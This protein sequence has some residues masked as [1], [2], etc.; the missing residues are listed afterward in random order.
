MRRRPDGEEP[1]ATIYVPAWLEARER[2]AS[3][4]DEDARALLTSAMEQ[5]ESAWE[6]VRGLQRWAEQHAERLRVDD[7]YGALLTFATSEVQ[8]VFRGL[9][10][11]LAALVEAWPGRDLPADNDVSARL[12][13]FAR[14]A[15]VLVLATGAAVDVPDEFR[16]LVRQVA[17]LRPGGPWA[18]GLAATFAAIQDVSD[19]EITADSARQAVDFLL[20]GIP[21]PD[22]E[23]IGGVLVGEV[24]AHYARAGQESPAW[25]EIVSEYFPA[26]PA[27]SAGAQAGE[28]Q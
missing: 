11:N 20:H 13:E 28:Q 26:A 18:T 10:F 17:Q 2:L 27:P 7:D 15:L 16:D 21:E 6:S 1:R 14:F 19:A 3:V 24:A 25:L 8:E 4:E 22:R 9:A 5:V 12:S 23:P